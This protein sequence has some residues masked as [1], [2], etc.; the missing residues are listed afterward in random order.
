MTRVLILNGPNLGRLGVR[1]PDVYGAASY[2][3]LVAA[4]ERWGAEN[5]LEVQVR[6]EITTGPAKYAPEEC[7]AILPQP[8][9]SAPSDASSSAM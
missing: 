1:E 3:D 9:T 5:D 7:I 2:A 8:E 6:T 4:G